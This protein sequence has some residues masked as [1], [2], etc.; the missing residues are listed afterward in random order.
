VADDPAKNLQGLAENLREIEMNE[1]INVVERNGEQAVRARDLHEA[2]GVKRAFSTW[3]KDRIEKYGFVEEEDFLPNLE[4]STGGR[5]GT[6]YLLSVGM[7]KEIA[8]V[9]NNEKGREIR[10][11]L[12][13]TEEAW[14]SPEAVVQRALQVSGTALRGQGEMMRMLDKEA[15]A[16]QK[17]S[18]DCTNGAGQRLAVA[19]LAYKGIIDSFLPVTDA[20]AIQHDA[21]RRK[22]VVVQKHYGITDET[23]DGLV[24][25]ARK[26]L[27][28]QKFWELGS[29]ETPK[30]IASSA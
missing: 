22:M 21:L 24:F 10:R 8:I 7:A 17:V 16:M 27:G 28:S 4:E 2:L 20:L 12:I 23:V 9:E 15:A 5:P 26:N 30:R 29:S 3:T 14:N 13:K 6:D 18:P 1:L 11:Y 25:E 19:V